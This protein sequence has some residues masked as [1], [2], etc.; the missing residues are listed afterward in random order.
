ML[1]KIDQSPLNSLNTLKIRIKLYGAL[2]NEA[3]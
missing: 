3:W 2:K 1:S